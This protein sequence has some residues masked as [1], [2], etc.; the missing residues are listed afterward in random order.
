MDLA[1]RQG[2][3]AVTMRTLARALRVEAMSLYHHLENR[4]AL[5]DG[6]VEAVFAEFVPPRLDEPWKVAMR[7]RAVA[8]RDALRRH[9]WAARLTLSRVATGPAALHYVDATLACLTAAGFSYAEADHA[10]S[11]IDHHIYGFVLQEASFPFRPEEYATQAARY[12]PLLAGQNLPHLE[13]LTRLV[14]T[15]AHSGVSDFF[16]GLDLIL[17]GLE[18]KLRR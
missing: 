4:E 5:L 18:R 7:R 15:G 11:A 6:M 3:E 16:F 17:D 1:D 14:A 9:P 8:A 12:L 10:W 13:Q 2:M